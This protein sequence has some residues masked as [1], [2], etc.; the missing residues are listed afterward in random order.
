MKDISK[1][2]LVSFLVILTFSACSVPVAGS[3]TNSVGGETST[4][5]VRSD[6][7]TSVGRRDTLTIYAAASL[8]EAF[9]ALGME[10]EAA[11]PGVKVE[12]S[13]AGSQV[14]R[15]QLEQGA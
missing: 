14:L 4:P 10:F 15:T 13:F 1:L 6:V 5:V 12:F 7:D 3:L 8:T 9:T 2:I 11:N